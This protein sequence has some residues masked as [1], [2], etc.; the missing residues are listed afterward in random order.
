MMPTFSLLPTSMYPLLSRAECLFGWP[1]HV[2][3]EVCAAASESERK[4]K[5]GAAQRTC[6]AKHQ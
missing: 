5:E 4:I 3:T 2:S 1:T 6:G